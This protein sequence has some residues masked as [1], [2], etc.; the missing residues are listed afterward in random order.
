ML[1]GR[2]QVKNVNIIVKGTSSLAG[3]RAID[4]FVLIK[5]ERYRGLLGNA[6]RL[7]AKNL[8]EH[9]MTS[10]CGEARDHAM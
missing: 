8:T 2:S 3:R 7:G 6:V 4:I 10:R 9:P 5:K 1:T